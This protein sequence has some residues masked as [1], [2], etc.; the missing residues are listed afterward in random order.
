MKLT[1]RNLVLAVLALALVL[2]GCTTRNNT[3]LLVDQQ[4]DVRDFEGATTTLTGKDAKVFY[5]DNDLVVKNLDLG[6]LYL[7]GGKLKEGIAHLNTAEALIEENYTKSLSAGAA[8]LLL[9][10]TAMPYGGED[11]E[12]LYLN[13]FKALAFAKQNEF[14]GAFVEIR[15]IT[16]KLNFFEDKYKK[17]ANEMNK[18]KAAGGNVKPGTREFYNSALARWI[19]MVLYRADRQFDN[20]AIDLKKIDEAF[21]E[22]K[23]VYNF[24]KPDLSGALAN[25]KGTYVDVV[26]FSGRA[27]LKKAITYRV[28]TYSSEVRISMEYE[29][30]KGVMVTSSRGSIF[31]PGV[32]GGYNF[33]CQVP[34]METKASPVRKVN[35][36]MDGQVIGTLQLIERM[37]QVAVA[38]FKLKESITYIKTIIRTVTKGIIAAKLKEEGQKSMSSMPGLGLLASIATD[39]AVEA[40]EGAD[41]RSGRYIPGY[42]WVGNFEVPAGSHLFETQYLD[43]NDTVIFVET[44]G[45]LTI[46]ERGLNLLSSV[47]ID[48]FAVPGSAKGRK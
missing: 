33:K 39:V 38:T 4:V 44:L 9:N 20:A 43:A 45:Q 19:S 26:A 2:A 34:T 16:D 25:T 46:K 48:K 47:S 10:D 23:T 22:Q 40:S 8:S 28:N 31:L 15:R 42:A 27:P 5:P 3:F 7:Y 17:I 37:D 11:Y 13:I 36:S 41:L 14:D 32:V 24:P 30:D 35:L 6:M 18:D 12:D 29:N 1:T 21:A